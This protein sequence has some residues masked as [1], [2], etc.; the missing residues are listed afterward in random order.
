MMK[1]KNKQVFW[2]IFW[3]PHF[4]V[5]FLFSSGLGL[6][7]LTT[8]WSEFLISIG[9]QG[10]IQVQYCLGWWLVLKVPKTILRE[11]LLSYFH[12]DHRFQHPRDLFLPRHGSHYPFSICW[13]LLIWM[14]FEIII[15]IPN[16]GVIKA[17]IGHPLPTPLV[18]PKS[19]L[20][21]P[22]AALLPKPPPLI[23]FCVSSISSV[24]FSGSSLWTSAPSWALAAI[25]L[26]PLYL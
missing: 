18:W 16:V 13:N 10:L 14:S 2:N 9:K 20:L 1:M 6:G 25:P 7:K 4:V 22:L 8:C 24:V 5:L 26:R 19:P 21:T 17:G 11:L 15:W 3:H 23:A 12:L